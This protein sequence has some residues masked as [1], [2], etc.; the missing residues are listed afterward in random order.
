M[1]NINYNSTKDFAFARFILNVSMYVF[2]LTLLKRLH[3]ETKKSLN[4]IKKIN[5][6]CVFAT[7]Y[8]FFRFG[9]IAKVLIFGTINRSISLR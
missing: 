6:I 9:K 5:C 3:R 7:T 8:N 1:M 2:N 4:P